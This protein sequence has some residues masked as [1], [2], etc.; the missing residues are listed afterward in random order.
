V[1][2]PRSTVPVEAPCDFRSR[3]TG[4]TGPIWCHTHDVPA[5][6]AA[7]VPVEALSAE[8]R[9][10]ADQGVERV[11]VHPALLRRAAAILAALPVP[12]APT[13]REGLTHGRHCP[14]SACARE[15]WTNPGLAPC[16]MHGP[17]CPPAYAP[18]AAATLPATPT[19]IDPGRLHAA[20]DRSIEDWSPGEA[21]LF[22]ATAAEYDR[23]TAEARTARVGQS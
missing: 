13:A 20:Y 17:A 5:N 7:T 19:G 21:G 23:L 14:C 1:T 15:D 2:E 22:E 4:N 8:L 16:G 6:H 18:I 12:D 10:C 11:E 3:W 9:R